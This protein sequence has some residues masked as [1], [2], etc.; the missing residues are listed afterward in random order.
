M[1]SFSRQSILVLGP[2]LASAVNRK[3]KNSEFSR[4]KSR[5]SSVIIHFL[6][7]SLYV[8]CMFIMIR[9]NDLTSFSQLLNKKKEERKKGEKK[10]KKRRRHKA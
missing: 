8:H 3:C 6:S 10:W 9:I 4:K 2:G 1:C 5:F 7:S